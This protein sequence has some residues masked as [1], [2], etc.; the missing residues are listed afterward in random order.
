MKKISPFFVGVISPLAL[1]LFYILFLTI[2]N[3]LQ[4]AWQQFL[5]LWPWMTLLLIGFGVQT[6]IFYHIH[7]YKNNKN[8]K[9]TIIATGGVSSGSMILCCT[10]H[11][12]DVIPL[13]GISGITLFLVEW[14]KFF[15][16]IGIIFNVVGIIFLLEV[17]QKNHLYEQG[18]FW[19]RIMYYNFQKMRWIVVWLGIFILIIIGIYR[20]R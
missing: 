2:F 15:L 17:V 10:H 14:Q 9:S 3:S 18:T 7:Q 5:L 12:T 11:V 8:G 20:W 1:F 13:L 4:H 19:E 16:L 6:G